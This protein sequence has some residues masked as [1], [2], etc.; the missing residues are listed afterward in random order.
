MVLNRRRSPGPSAALIGALCAFAVVSPL[1]HAAFGAQQVGARKGAES[2]AALNRQC[3]EAVNRAA[4]DAEA[5]VPHRFWT[6]RLDFER[7]RRDLAQLRRDL[8]ALQEAEAGFDAALT[9]TERETLRAQRQSVQQLWSHLESDAD[10]LDAE[11]RKGYPTRWHVARDASDMEKEIHRL[12]RLHE[13]IARE[14]GLER[15]R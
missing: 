15:S 6:W 2:R 7:T 12:K 3:V 10:S 1:D 11:L 5:M 9:D 13:R 14:V 8:T 4:R